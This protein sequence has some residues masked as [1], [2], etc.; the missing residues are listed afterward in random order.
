M[1]PVLNN[2]ECHTTL[3]ITE[4]MTGVAEIDGAFWLVSQDVFEVNSWPACR[5]GD[6][7][8]Y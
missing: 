5:M 4:T 6:I 8:G 2:N 3:S 1:N 7:V